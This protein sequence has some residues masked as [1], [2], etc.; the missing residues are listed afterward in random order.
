MKI[1]PARNSLALAFGV[2]LSLAPLAAAPADAGGLTLSN[3]ATQAMD[4]IYDGDPGAAIAIARRLEQSRP[5]H[6][7]GYLLEDE[8][9]WWNTYCAACEIKWGMLDAWKQGKLP[10][11]GT[12]LALADKAIYLARSQ[13]AKSD[14][15]DMHLYAGIAW[16][17]KTRLY[18]LRDEHRA[19]A[20]SAVSARAEFLRCL[21]LDPQMA[22]ATAG[23]GLY[24]YYVDTLSPVIKLLRF[25][26]GIPGGNKE[27]GLR[28]MQT[29]M[30][31]GVLLAVDT[32]FY[33][34]K[35]LRTYDRK[36]EQALSVAE[37]LGARYPHNPVFFLLLGNL[38]AE[39][40]RS[41]KASEYFDAALNLSI[42]D[43]AC[44]A[45]VRYLAN[46]FLA[47]LH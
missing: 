16:A 3:Q 6:P 45:R 35:S 46:S 5:E 37:P 28:Q 20:R 7:L 22:D 42:P 27:E 29:G 34:A 26:M 15:A 21:Q 12:Y 11:D 19:A 44:A 41:A 8:A 18:G 14:T 23:L 2:I 30:E 40:G 31:Q 38:N 39:L 10:E 9:L 47:L 24:N 36:Y 1:M 25:F 32:R 33:L 13:I 4:K 43:A 17:L